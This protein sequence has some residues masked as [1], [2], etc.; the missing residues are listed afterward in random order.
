MALSFLQVSV[1]A[2]ICVI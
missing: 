1:S 2:D